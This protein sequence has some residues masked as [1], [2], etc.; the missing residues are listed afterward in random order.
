[1][2]NCDVLLSCFLKNK[3]KIVHERI[4]YIPL[5]LIIKRKLKWYKRFL[6]ASH[7]AELRRF[8]TLKNKS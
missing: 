4:K 1:M 6:E 8:L 5:I 7:V 3:E 2:I